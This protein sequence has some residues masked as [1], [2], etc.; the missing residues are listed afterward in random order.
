MAL[1]HIHYFVYEDDA[2][3]IIVRGPQL[4]SIIKYIGDSQMPRTML[5]DDCLPA[6]QTLI[7]DVIQEKTDDEE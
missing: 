1:Q 4:V 7:D 5:Y 3:E 6:V 2:Y